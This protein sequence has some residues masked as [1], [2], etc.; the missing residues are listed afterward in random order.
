MK[1]SVKFSI[2]VLAVCLA[3]SLFFNGYLY[4]QIENCPEE[5]GERY[6]PTHFSFV[7]SPGQQKITNETLYV[8][9]TF[10]R[11]GENLSMIIRINDDDYDVMESLWKINPD[12]LIICFDFY[13]N[14]SAISIGDP[15]MSYLLR[16]DNTSNPTI[17]GLFLDLEL[18]DHY[19][20]PSLEFSES[21]FHYCT[22]KPNEGYIFN[23]TFPLRGL[24]G[25]PMELRRIRSDVVT[26]RYK[27]VNGSVYIPPFHFGVDVSVED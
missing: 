24:E 1:T 16:P 5:N 12:T 13:G 21:D 7:W 23:C 20:G 19:M 15:V 17:C 6:G 11:I 4:L 27:D 8:N 10:E 18:I 22:F 3:V 14:D 26:L 9:M 2:I 25:Y